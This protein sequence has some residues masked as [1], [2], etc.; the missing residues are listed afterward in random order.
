MKIGIIVAMTVEFDLV[1]ATMSNC[2]PATLM[3]LQICTGCM[4]GKDVILMKGGIGKVN[5]S[6]ATS[7]MII[8]Y[9][10]DCIISTG[11]AGGIDRILSVGD[12]VV[13]ETTCYHDFY[14]GEAVTQASAGVADIINADP[15]L[16]SGM[17]SV[18][19][20]MESVRF[21]LICTGDQ[22]IDNN[23][24]LME[25]K[26]SRPTGLAV[27]MES[28]AIAH[29]C[30]AYDVPFIS[31]RIISD[32][33]WV[34]AHTEQYTNFWNEAPQKLFALARTMIASL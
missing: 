26:A 20:S 13:G 17:R 3:G 24:K 28:N 16:L 11:V 7:A 9:H 5:A 22:F 4:E 15:S 1:K 10:P 6:I 25:I 27:D 21:G 33:P 14:I 29:T 23:D 8:N 2:Q 34:E 18:A 31:F 30:G 19:A 32:T 12:I